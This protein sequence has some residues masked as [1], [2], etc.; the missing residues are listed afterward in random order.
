MKKTWSLLALVM[1]AALLLAACGTPEG[2]PERGRGHPTV[3]AL[4]PVEPTEAPAGRAAPTVEAPAPV[5]P[6]ERLRA[7]LLPP[8]NR[9]PRSTL[10]PQ[11]KRQPQ[12][13][14]IRWPERAGSG[15][16]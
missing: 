16:R 12:L 4:A 7:R 6:T 5:E 15:C 13:N 9:Q 2:A 10:P 1:I 11:S 3:E 8:P 14:R